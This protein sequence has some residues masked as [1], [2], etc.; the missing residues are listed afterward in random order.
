M[1]YEG[2]RENSHP[3]A[4]QTQTCLAPVG[5]F[6]RCPESNLLLLNPG[7]SAI[8]AAASPSAIPQGH[9]FSE[10]PAQLSCLM[11]LLGCFP[12]KVPHSAAQTPAFGSLMWQEEQQLLIPPPP[13]ILTCS[14]ALLENCKPE[15]G[16][17]NRTG[18]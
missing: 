7:V 15:Q 8:A 9:E 2:F 3:S 5:S 6:T 17:G 16:R 12:L 4:G 1:D 14:A 18:A 10:P 11:S 13:P